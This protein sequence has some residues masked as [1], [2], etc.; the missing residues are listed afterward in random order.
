MT[1]KDRQLAAAYP[2]APGELS[3]GT[4]VSPR[5]G[6]LVGGGFLAAFLFYGVGALLVDDLT[7]DPNPVGQVLAHTS[8]LRVG[9]LLMLGNSIIVAAIGAALYP[10]LKTRHPIVGTAYL[11]GRT[12]EAILLAIGG[13]FVLMTLPAAEA[14]DV[15]VV[16][17]LIEGNNVAYQVGMLGLGVASIGFCWVLLQEQLVPKRL[18]LLG[19][20]GYAVFATGT[21]LEL[22]D[23]GV[24]ALLSIPAGLFEVAFG[25]Y[26]I[27]RGLHHGHSPAARPIST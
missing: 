23:I 6:R 27:A 13:I 1:I 11:M 24:G 8:Q 16:D 7:S 25:I 2:A 20:V 19:V 21:I 17:A 26:V 15:T 4:A 5:V 14:G 3:E 10:V 22:F 18:A 12:F 9:V